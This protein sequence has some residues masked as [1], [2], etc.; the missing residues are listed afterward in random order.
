MF[1]QLIAN[2]LVMLSAILLIAIPQYLWTVFF[3]RFIAGTAHG[4]AYVAVVQHFGELVV[5]DQRGKIGTALHLFLLKGGIISGHATIKFFSAYEQM[6]PNRFLGIC[7]LFLSIIAFVMTLLFYKESILTLIKEGRD[8]DAIKTMIDLRLEAE[9]TAEINETYNEWKNMIAQEKWTDGDIFG[10]GNTKPLIIV[11]LVRVAFVISYNYGIKYIHIVAT[12]SSSVD[13][14]FIL[15]LLHIS[16]TFLVLFTIDRIGR[17]RH[18]LISAFTTAAVLIVFGGLRASV[19]ANSNLAVFIIFVVFEVASAF[20]LGMTAHIYSTE[21]FPS[22]K[23]PASIAFTS[24]IEFS[25][26]IIYVIWVENIIYSRMFDVILLIL[27]GI[28]LAGIAI[29]LSFSLP[30]TKKLSIR[31]ACNK[32]LQ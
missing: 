8:D 5:D 10:E 3:A 22:P 30:E 29:Y 11:S 21:A 23:K 18:F 24:I 19:F 9:V 31:K 13:Y 32:F 28:A 25:V 2:F 14:T 7:S 15:N 1:S 17:R 4:V 20:G 16:A 27:S 26:Q 6:D 12:R